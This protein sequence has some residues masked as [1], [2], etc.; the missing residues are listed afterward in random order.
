MSHK[1][2]ATRQRE[3]QQRK[4]THLP[5]Q[6]A[7]VADALSYARMNR[8]DANSADRLTAQRDALER[9]YIEA[10]Y[11]SVEAAGM[12]NAAA[13]GKP[14]S[15]LSGP[16]KGDREVEPESVADAVAALQSMVPGIVSAQAA[17][18]P[19]RPAIQVVAIGSD[20]AERKLVVNLSILEIDKLTS[21][22]QSVGISVFKLAA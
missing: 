16:P 19:F 18:H 1:D 12:A 17:P 21:A 22:L 11:S 15:W 6:E 9:A 5:R 13:D 10:G 4:R 14:G 8:H 20:G 3:A 7:L 2:K